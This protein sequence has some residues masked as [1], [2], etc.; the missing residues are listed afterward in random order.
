MLNIAIGFTVCLSLVAAF[1]SWGLSRDIRSL[2]KRLNRMD[3]AIGLLTRRLELRSSDEKQRIR[4][5]EDV[6]RGS[7]GQ[8][9]FL[10][11]RIQKIE[12]FLKTQG[13]E[14]TTELR[15]TSENVSRLDLKNSRVPNNPVSPVPSPRQP[16]RYIK[17][18]SEDVASRV[19]DMWGLG[20]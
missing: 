16:S 4:T 6:T 11:G 13:Y 18:S 2:R 19:K 17:P 10:L 8:L 5:L 14:T 12:D 9:K 20:N 3:D 15:G 1:R 7:Q